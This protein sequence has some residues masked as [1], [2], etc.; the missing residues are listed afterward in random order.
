MSHIPSLPHPLS[1]IQ[2]QLHPGAETAAVARLFRVGPAH[3]DVAEDA[4]G[5]RHHG[6]KAAIGRCDGGEAARAAIGVE[7]VGFV[8]PNSIFMV[9]V[10]PAP[11][12]PNRP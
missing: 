5:M 7:R 6:G 8:K 3:L 12:L 9:V 11:F 2:P 10:F 4:L 1:R